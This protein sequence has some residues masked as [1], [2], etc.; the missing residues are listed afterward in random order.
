[1]LN[2]DTIDLYFI[3]I[4]DEAKKIAFPLSVKARDKGLNIL[5]SFGSPSMK[6]Q[7]KKAHQ[8]KAKYVAIIGIMEARR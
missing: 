3:Q 7:M 2:K 4:G 6:T 5:S 8:L 1:M